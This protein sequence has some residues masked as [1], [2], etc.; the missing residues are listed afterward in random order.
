MLLPVYQLMRIGITKCPDYS[1]MQAHLLLFFI[2]T[3]PNIP[4]VQNALK[5]FQVLIAS[6]SR[7]LNHV[8]S[9]MRSP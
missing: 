5:R 7:L 9:A 3:T 4:I 8:S 6:E 2:E 1:L